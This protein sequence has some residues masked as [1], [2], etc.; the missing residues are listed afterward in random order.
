MNRSSQMARGLHL[1]IRPEIGSYH[2]QLSAKKDGFLEDICA[3]SEPYSNRLQ[4]PSASYSCAK[5][6][7]AH[8]HR[9]GANSSIP[10]VLSCT[11]A[12]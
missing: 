12:S 1:I 7:K 6:S 3:S 11:Q 9:A 4:R 2:R 5:L 8:L 10:D